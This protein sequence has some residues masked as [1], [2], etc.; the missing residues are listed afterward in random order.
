LVG[1]EKPTVLA[2]SFIWQF[3]AGSELPL[4]VLAAPANENEKKHAQRLLE[5]AVKASKGKIMVF[6]ADSQYSSRRLR[7]HIS[8]HGIKPVIPY[9]SNQKAV[10]PNTY[11]L[12][13]ASEPM[14]LKG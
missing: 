13:K 10:K 12:T 7:K 3:D 4:A 14:D 8:S 11:A 6:V 5:K 2:T 1:L 9:P